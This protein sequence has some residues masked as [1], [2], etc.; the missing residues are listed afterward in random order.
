MFEPSTEFRPTEPSHGG[1]P[2]PGR[3]GADMSHNDAISWWV[4]QL[5]TG[6]RVVVNES[7]SCLQG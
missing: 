3:S 2:D 1:R 6:I 4:A 7:G 5:G